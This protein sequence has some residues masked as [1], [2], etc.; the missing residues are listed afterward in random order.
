MAER[1]KYG[2]T[3]HGARIV[4]RLVED[5][6]LENVAVGPELEALLRRRRWSI[7]INDEAPVEC[8]DLPPEA[9]PERRLREWYEDALRRKAIAV[10]P[11][12]V[13]WAASC[14]HCGRPTLRSRP[15][16]DFQRPK[17]SEWRC[18]PCRSYFLVPTDHVFFF[19]RT[20]NRRLHDEEVEFDE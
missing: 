12:E 13:C 19:D 2:F 11:R 7:W 15:N 6:S 16:G 8:A 10:P 17:L 1:K 4:F 9:L 20:Y 3:D 5:A 14:P 18:A